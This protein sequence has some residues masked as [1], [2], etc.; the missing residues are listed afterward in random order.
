MRVIK[1]EPA[2]SI[3]RGYC[4]IDC[5]DF[6]VA[7]LTDSQQGVVGAHA[8]VLAANLQTA[9]EVLFDESDAV[10]QRV[11]GDDEVVQLAVL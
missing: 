4:G 8:G 6:E 10:L 5:D 2:G 9:A 1:L 7:G 11:C 3:D